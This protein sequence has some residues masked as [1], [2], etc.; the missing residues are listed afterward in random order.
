VLLENVP[1]LAKDSRFKELLDVLEILGYR[2]EWAVLNAAAFG[3]PQRRK[4]LIMISSRVGSIPLPEGDEITVSV[5]KTIGD[6]PRPGKSKDRLH[7]LVMKNSKRIK[8]LISKIPD[9]G[10]S[11]SALGARA[12]LA[13]HKKTKGFRDIYG[14]MKWEDVSPTITSGCTNPSKGRFLHPVQDRPIS[15]R[16]AALLQTFPKRYR[17]PVDVGITKMA[18]LVGDALPPIFALRQGRQIA[19]FLLEL[20]NHKKVD[21]S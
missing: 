9:D 19:S 1:G 11:R 21:K 14:R 4:R 3:V 12:Q 8:K 16:E 2:S 7:R 10:G 13:C 6:L 18:R 5:K 17:F 20:K 15:I